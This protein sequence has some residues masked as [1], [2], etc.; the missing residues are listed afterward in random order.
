MC[1][2]NDVGVREG[3]LNSIVEITGEQW[4]MTIENVCTFVLLLFT[5]TISQTGCLFYVCDYLVFDSIFCAVILH[6]NQIYFH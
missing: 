2:A 4:K 6:V 5:S 1:I 3:R